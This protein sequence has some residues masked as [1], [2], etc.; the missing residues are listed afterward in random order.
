MM[1]YC[2]DQNLAT[3]AAESIVGGAK[4]ELESNA[5]EEEMFSDEGRVTPV[6]AD[7]EKDEISDNSEHESEDDTEEEPSP[8]EGTVEEPEDQGNTEEQEDPLPTVGGAGSSAAQEQSSGGS[9]V[10]TVTGK[11]VMVDGRMLPLDLVSLICYGK[12]RSKLQGN[13]NTIQQLADCFDNLLIFGNGSNI[14]NNSAIIS[15]PTQI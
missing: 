14:I 12:Y 9:N 3:M 13:N 10:S 2:V 6:T 7:I 11:E 5:A 8:L 1:K 4:D 15:S